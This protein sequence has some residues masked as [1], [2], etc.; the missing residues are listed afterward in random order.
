MPIAQQDLPAIVASNNK[1]IKA[2]IGL[3]ALRDPEL[4]GELRAVFAMAGRA[5]ESVSPAE[6]RTWAQVRREIDFITHMVEGDGD[7]GGEPEPPAA[8][9][10]H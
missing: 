3:L 9:D 4:L 5:D 6:A 8:S 7:L 2:L 1:L 10:R